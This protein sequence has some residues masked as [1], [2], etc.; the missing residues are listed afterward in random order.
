MS[1]N[2]HNFSGICKTIGVAML[3]L[4]AIFSL[5]SFFAL[6]VPYKQPDI[7]DDVTAAFK[8]GDAVQLATFLNST[9][10]I[11]LVDKENVFSK[12][13]AERVLNDFFRKNKTQSFELIYKSNSTRIISYAIGSLSTD[14][15]IYRTYYSVNFVA[16]R[17][18][19]K[20]LRIEKNN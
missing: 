2:W 5:V 17:A 7:R 10:K 14:K 19:I 13:Q 12:V 4:L 1:I 3:K 18:F 8:A 16:N 6:N 15:G 9:V 11:T 20:E